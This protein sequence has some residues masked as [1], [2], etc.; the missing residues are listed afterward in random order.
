MST[1]VIVD[2]DAGMASA[3]GFDK[4]SCGDGVICGQRT[5]GIQ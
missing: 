3:S 4:T 1:I 2:G 5:T